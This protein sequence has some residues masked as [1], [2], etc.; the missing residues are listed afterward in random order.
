MNKPRDG[1][2]ENRRRIAA[3]SY[4]IDKTDDIVLLK[5]LRSGDVLIDVAKR[6]R[7]KDNSQS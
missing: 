6:S 5:R 1:S 7:V 3:G 2:H 4:R